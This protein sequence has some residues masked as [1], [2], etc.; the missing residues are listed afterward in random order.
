MRIQVGKA[1]KVNHQVIG[2]F[3]MLVTTVDDAF[4]KGHIVENANK[5]TVSYDREKVKKRIS[6]RRSIATFEEV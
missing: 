3:N 6:V 2:K 1:Y 5:H 4:I